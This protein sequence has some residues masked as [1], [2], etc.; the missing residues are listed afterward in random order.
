MLPTGVANMTSFQPNCGQQSHSFASR[1][2]VFQARVGG[3]EETQGRLLSLLTLFLIL[4]L[5]VSRTPAL[6]LSHSFSV[7]LRSSQAICIFSSSN[8]IIAFCATHN[9]RLSRCRSCSHTHTTVQDICTKCSYAKGERTQRLLRYA[10]VMEEDKGLVCAQ[11]QMKDGQTDICEVCVCQLYLWEKC[12]VSRDQP[13]S[14]LPSGRFCI[15]VQSMTS[16]PYPAPRCVSCFTALGVV[17]VCVRVCPS[18]SVCNHPAVKN[19]AMT[20]D[21]FYSHE[22]LHSLQEATR[23]RHREEDASIMLMA[24]GT[25][26]D[27]VSSDSSDAS[28]SLIFLGPK[29]RMCDLPGS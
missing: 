11:E 21:G 10:T 25:A 20:D 5:M 1:D 8:V 4:F 17:C 2:H 18:V 26:G 9:K 29:Q 27:T 3:K 15:R 24:L 19:A 23:W 16:S 6:S 12:V 13:T 7:V 22:R 14:L 28:A